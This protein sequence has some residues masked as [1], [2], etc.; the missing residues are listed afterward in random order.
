MHSFRLARILFAGILLGC[1]LSS[2]DARVHAQR[3]SE[4][5]DLADA[6]LYPRDLH[7]IG[8]PGFLVETALW[9][10]PDDALGVMERDLDVD[11]RAV[12]DQFSEDGGFAFSYVS[13]LSLADKQDAVAV[14]IRN[15]LIQF[16]SESD[17]E[18]AFAALED[19]ID[20]AEAEID[21]SW[22]DDSM[23]VST[24][25]SFSLLIR[26]QQVLSVVTID[27]DYLEQEDQRA[28]FAAR[29]IV[30]GDRSVGQIQRALD[31]SGSEFGVTAVRFDPEAPDYVV[32]VDRF[33]VDHGTYVPMAD[34]SYEPAFMGIQVDAFQIETL[35]NR[36]LYPS[37]TSGAIVN[38]TITSHTS[39]AIAKSYVSYFRDRLDFGGGYEDLR[40]VDDL[41]FPGDSWSAFN[42]SVT[43]SE[44]LVTSGLAISVQIGNQ[45]VSATVDSTDG[46]DTGEMLA[47]VEMQV[48]CLIG[49]GCETVPYPGD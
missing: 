29:M 44:E 31:R 37:G 46:V 49:T 36:F 11:D 33:T 7:A 12:E 9:V 30:L 2:G 47:I 10:D 24:D 45:V 15:L 38:L 26:E 25:S 14:G 32:S 48:S 43:Y 13:R 19:E 18:D 27:S 42:Y 20:S 28:V 5:Y 35:Y 17:A 4:R 8:L 40:P 22:G 16:E 21:G 41:V 23:A 39:S 1:A 3:S 34:A 6:V